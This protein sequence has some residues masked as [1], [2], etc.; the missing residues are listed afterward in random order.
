MTTRTIDAGKWGFTLS[1][2]D[3]QSF[4]DVFASDIPATSIS[5]DV[6]AEG[7]TPV[8]VVLPAETEIDSAVFALTGNWK[9]LD[10]DQKPMAGKGVFGW[11]LGAAGLGLGLAALRRRK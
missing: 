1:E 10:G 11:A 8:E 5:Y 7:G 4:F 6:D 9:R 3:L 2:E